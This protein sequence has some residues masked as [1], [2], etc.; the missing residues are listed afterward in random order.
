MATW[1]TTGGR[2]GR[3]LGSLAIAAAAATGIVVIANINRPAVALKSA[4]AVPVAGG[5][6]ITPAPGWTIAKRGTDWV[7]LANPDSS[8]QLQVAVKPA[9]G[10]D[11]VGS[12]QA[13][14]RRLTGTPAAGLTN[15]ED[16][17]APITRP[18]QGNNFQQEAFINYTA[19]VTGPQGPIPV[20]GTF[21]EL[22]NTST[23][24]TAFIDFRQDDN[25]TMLVDNDG[26]AMIKS[27]C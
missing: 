14:V 7:A 9:S 24:R 22:L 16:L 23:R 6:S 10:A 27:L 19:D 2:F 1:S 3:R 11:L 20:L 25:A 13:D 18:L 15:V 8:A 26:G 4:D 12:L 17:G 21:D 5:I